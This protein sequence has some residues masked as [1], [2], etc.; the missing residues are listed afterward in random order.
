ML[1]AT[2][3]VFSL[4]TIMQLINLHSPFSKDGTLSFEEFKGVQAFLRN[5][6]ASFQYFDTSRNG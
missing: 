1:A 6:Q 3:L 2:G 4:Q 5:I